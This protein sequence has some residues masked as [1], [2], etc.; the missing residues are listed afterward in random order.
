MRALCR[1]VAAPFAIAGAA[2]ACGVL[3]V[4][5]AAHSVMETAGWLDD[6]WHGEDSW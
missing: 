2:I 3:L 6:G 4:A 5:W 1:L